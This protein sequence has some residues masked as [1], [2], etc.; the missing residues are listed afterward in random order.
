MSGIIPFRPEHKTHVLSIAEKEVGKNFIHAGYLDFFLTNADTAGIVAIYESAIV[1]FS[2]FQWC[3]P[4]ELHKYIFTE[5]EWLEKIFLNIPIVG[6]RNLIAVKKEFQNKGIGS[7]LVD[8]SMK[9]LRKKSDVITS[10]V[11][12]PKELKDI[13]GLLENHNL[14]AVKIIPDYWKEDSLRRKYECAV[15]GTPP[16]TCTAE[17]YV[18]FYYNKNQR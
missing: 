14:N 11:W 15:C 18:G 4:S 2:F 6:Y 12:K 17:I 9:E 1:G 10:V 3:K 13:G 5:K 7:A 8:Q 16:C